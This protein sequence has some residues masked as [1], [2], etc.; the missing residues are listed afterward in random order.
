ML[1]W[2]RY[3]RQLLLVWFNKVFYSGKKNYG[4]LKNNS[5]EQNLGT[6]LKVELS[7]HLRYR[8]FFLAKLA[9]DII[10][11]ETNLR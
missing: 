1:S 6:A 2:V 7:V 3:P 4:R 10:N 9:F 5:R 8:F 11:D